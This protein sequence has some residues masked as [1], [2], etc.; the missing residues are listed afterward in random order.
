[1]TETHAGSFAFGFASQLR[2]DRFAPLDEKR[3]E[4][5]STA[6][7]PSGTAGA[8]SKSTRP[9]SRWSGCRSFRVLSNQLFQR[10]LNDGKALCREYREAFAL[11]DASGYF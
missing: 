7:H 11:A 3:F 9:A 5:W 2:G 6:E 8:W 1:M 4:R 10:D